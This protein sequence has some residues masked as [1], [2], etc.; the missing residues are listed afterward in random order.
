MLAM[1]KRHTGVLCQAVRWIPVTEKEMD[2]N[3]ACHA[4]G[5]METVVSLSA[6]RTDAWGAISR[7]R[8]NEGLFFKQSDIRDRYV[9]PGVKDHAKMKPNILAVTVRNRA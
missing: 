5:S 8:F 9:L 2:A 7:H 3:N 4:P 1:P 6:G